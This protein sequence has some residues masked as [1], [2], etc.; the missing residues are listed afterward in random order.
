MNIIIYIII[1]ILVSISSYYLFHYYDKLSNSDN[2]RINLPVGC[3]SGI[4]WPI[5]LTL[6]TLFCIGYY[7]ECLK[8]KYKKII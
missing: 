4:V 2:G 5:S 3:I 1:G 8:D 6:I 7:Y